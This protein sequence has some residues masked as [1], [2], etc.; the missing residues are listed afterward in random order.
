MRKGKLLLAV[1]VT[2]GIALAGFGAWR[3]LVPQGPERQTRRIQ[4]ELSPGP[5]SVAP[6]FTLKTFEG[7]TLSLRNLLGKPIVMNFWASW[8]GPCQLE[9]RN[10]EKAWKAFRN[11]GVVFLG[12][13]VVDDEGDAREFLRA[14]KVTYPNVRDPTQ[15]VMTAYRVTALPTTIFITRD[16]RIRRTYLGAFLG[17]EGYQ[18]LI[19]WTEELLEEKGNR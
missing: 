7:R 17:E 19:Q 14:F 12:V 4:R 10:L 11:R 2:L 3:L 18:R 5:L 16:G 1:A 8:C 6:D 15:H 13:N 9:A